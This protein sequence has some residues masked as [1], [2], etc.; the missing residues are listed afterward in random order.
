M[1]DRPVMPDL[2]NVDIAAA[3]K[4]ALEDRQWLQNQLS[5]TEQCFTAALDYALEDDDPEA[6]L[7]CWA[8]GNFDA[9]RAEWSDA[10]EAVFFA[11]PEG[12][13]ND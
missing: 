10:P 1:S 7:R 11:D 5:Q 3:Y 2:L 8:E 9:I 4:W 13:N 12:N 6:F